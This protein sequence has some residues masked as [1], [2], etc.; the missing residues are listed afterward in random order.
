MFSLIWKQEQLKPLAQQLARVKDLPV[1]EFG[2]LQ[3]WE[4]K[5][6]AVAHA[7]GDANGGDPT[8]SSQGQGYGGTPMPFLGETSV[9]IFSCILKF[10]VFG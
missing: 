6:S 9:C 1:P 7:N 5:L 10:A 3:A 4:A 8:K 2:T